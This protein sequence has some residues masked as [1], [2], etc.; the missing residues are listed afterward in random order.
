VNP[1]P[2]NGPFD[3]A[4]SRQ[5]SL[6]EETAD[7]LELALKLDPDDSEARE[8]LEKLRAAQVVSERAADN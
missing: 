1:F 2:C 6:L 5:S 8:I 4:I 3:R 7:L